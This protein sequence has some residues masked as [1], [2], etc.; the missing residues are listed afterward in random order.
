[1][2][3]YDDVKKGIQDFLAPDIKEIKG[4]L[5]AINVRLDAMEKNTDTRFNAMGKNTDTRFQAIEEKL[6]SRFNGIDQRFDDLIE[7]LELDRRIEKL[8]RQH[9]EGKTN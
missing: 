4:E 9:H 7:R 2:S 6:T 5:K 1:M 8:E 3:V